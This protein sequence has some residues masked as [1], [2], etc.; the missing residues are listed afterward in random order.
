MG[1]YLMKNLKYPAESERRAEQGRVVI[2]CI[3]MKDGSIRDA[4]VEQGF[5]KACDEEA[6]RVVSNMPAWTPGKLNGEIM[7]VRVL[8]PI[9]FT[10]RIERLQ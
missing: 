6:L 3:V 9:V 8:V 7:N 1:N 4:R 5:D 10:L 2:S